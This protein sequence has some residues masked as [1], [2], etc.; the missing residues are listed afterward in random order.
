MVCHLDDK[1][2]RRGVFLCVAD[3]E[4]AIA[5]EMLTRYRRTLEQI[6]PGVPA[7][8]S[9]KGSDGLSSYFADTNYTTLHYTIWS[10]S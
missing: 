8:K 1:A 10:Y 6:K 9:G 7:P 2:I 3:L 4:A 5:Q